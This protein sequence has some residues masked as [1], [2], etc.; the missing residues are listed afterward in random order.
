[1]RKT[2]T[3]FSI[4]FAQF[5]EDNYVSCEKLNCQKSGKVCIE[6][7]FTNECAVKFGKPCKGDTLCQ[8]GSYC[9][10][11]KVCGEKYGKK[12][13]EKCTT[14]D[15]EIGLY[16][17]QVME[18]LLDQEKKSQ[19]VQVFVRIRPFSPLELENRDLLSSPIS[20]PGTSTREVVCNYKGYSRSYQF[21][22]VFD[23]E[24]KQKDLFNVTVKPIADEVLSGFNGTIFVY[25]QTGTGKTYTMEGRMDSIEENGIIPRT[26]RYIFDTLEKAGSDYNVRVSHLEIYK[27][28]I[29]DLLSCSNEH[30]VLNAFN[31]NKKGTTVPDLEEILVNDTQSILSILAKSCKR[32]MTAETFYNKQSS[33]SH[34][35]FTITIHVK[36]TTIS[37]EDLIKIGKLNLVDLAGSEGAQKSGTNDRLREAALINQSLLTLGRVITALTTDVNGH[38]PYRDSKLTRLLQDSLGGKTKT[39]LI[40]TVS[41]SIIN[42]EETLNTLEYA[43]KAKNIKN[44][45]TI[46]QKMSKNSLLKE[47]SAE[48]ARLKQLLQAAYDKDGVYLTMDVYRAMEKEIEDKKN[49][50]HNIDFQYM[51]AKHE[52]ESVRKSFTD[53]TELLEEVIRDLDSSKQSISQLKQQINEKNSIINTFESQDNNLRGTLNETL[54]DLDKLH[55]KLDHAKSIESENIKSSNDAKTIL[56]KRIGSLNQLSSTLQKS[57]SDL[58]DSLTS[59]F[60]KIYDIQSK[61][62]NE[63]IKKFEGISQLIETSYD[64]LYSINQRSIDSSQPLVKIGKASDDLFNRLDTLITSLKDEVAVIIDEL[65]PVSFGSNHDIINNCLSL[66]SNNISKSVQITKEQEIE[67]NQLKDI[68]STWTVKQNQYIVNQKKFY[69]DLLEKHSNNRSAWEK[70]FIGKISQVV[71]QFS[72]NYADSFDVYKD[73]ISNNMNYFES[74]LNSVQ[75]ESQKRIN[76]IHSNISNMTDFNKSFSKEINNSLSILS[77]DSVVVNNKLKDT[78]ETSKK[79][80]ESIAN[81]CNDVNVKHKVSV[82]QFNDSLFNITTGLSTQKELL[83][84]LKSQNI[85]YNRSDIL[86]IMEK[87]KNQLKD[88][89]ESV[90][91][92]IDSHKQSIQNTTELSNNISSIINSI[93]KYF[94]IK[95]IKTTGNTPVKK[96]INIKSPIKNNTSTTTTITPNVLQKSTKN[97]N[98]IEDKENQLKKSTNGS[99]V[100][101]QLPKSSQKSK[102]QP[103]TS[104]T[105]KQEIKNPFTP[106]SVINENNQTDLKSSGKI[107]VFSGTQNT[108]RSNVVKSIFEATPKT[109][110]KEKNSLL[111]LKKSLV[112]IPP[113]VFTN[114]IVLNI[115]TPTNPLLKKNDNTGLTAGPSSKKKKI[116][117]P[118]FIMTDS[119]KPNESAKKKTLT[120]SSSSSSSSGSSNDSPFTS[121][122]QQPQQQQNNLKRKLISTPKLIDSDDSS[123]DDDSMMMD[124]LKKNKK[125]KGLEHQQPTKLPK[126]LSS[127]SLST[128]KKAIQPHSPISIST[129]K[130]SLTSIKKLS[131][132]GILKPISRPPSRSNNNQNNTNNNISLKSRQSNK[133]N[134]FQMDR[135][136]TSN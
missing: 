42:I 49:Q 69:Q 65:L 74:E 30:K 35:I 118:S 15:C 114:P 108:P 117:N 37:G 6:S 109:K 28:E 46:N 54:S 61:N 56:Q 44:T 53:Q 38:I 92:N 82:K 12:L 102:P 85:Q 41:P 5:F 133:E 21:D 73:T 81:S 105:D 116:P 115:G 104:N 127:L 51:S 135:Q 96:S 131:S 136:T 79:K 83:D 93:P 10:N 100:E 91:Q 78:I 99:N 1:M 110:S 45:P 72:N 90:S 59:Q 7:G 18:K 17:D 23:S 32:R 2:S 64:Q 4:S 25:G 95:K 3:F 8:D 111:S 22:H 124:D 97:N 11:R 130:A 27:E 126:T 14:N 62:N 57:Q 33:R 58:Y 89:I 36:E 60:S 76:Q 63:I 77:T 80:I 123:N 103:A 50:L 98:N 75:S 107:M 55:N 106:E 87:S 47:Q 52:I 120:S 129:R 13:N 9:Y 29:F 128:A 24:S 66:I 134:I 16:C 40:A 101:N 67:I 84:K 112:N 43:M 48:I 86:P 119:P 19:N 113:P 20:C 68:F 34:C 121:P 132:S 26:I 71:S 39:C 94:E 88:Q 70:K 122:K 31:D 125:Q